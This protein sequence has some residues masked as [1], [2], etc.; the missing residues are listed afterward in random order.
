MV[1]AYTGENVEE[2]FN[3]LIKQL[4]EKNKTTNVTPVKKN[5]FKLEDNKNKNRNV[6]R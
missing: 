5:T 3:Y 4:V 6:S 2:A 1:S